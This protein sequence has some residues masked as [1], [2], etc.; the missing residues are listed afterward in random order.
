MLEDMSFEG[1]GGEMSSLRIYNWTHIKNET[2][3]AKHS[4]E[5][6]GFCS[7]REGTLSETGRPSKRRQGWRRKRSYRLGPTGRMTMDSLVCLQLRVL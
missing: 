2:I 7:I 4:G 5:A 3:Y 6:C 1:H